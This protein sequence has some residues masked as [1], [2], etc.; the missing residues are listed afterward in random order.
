LILDKGTEYWGT[1]PFKARGGGTPLELLKQYVVATGRKPRYLLVDNA[2]E[3]ISQ[4]IVDYCRDNNTILQQ[5]VAYNHTMQA[6]VEGAIVCFKQHSRVAL[7]CAN[8]S[9][10]FWPDATLDFKCKRN[11]IWAKRDEHGQLFTANDRLQPAFEGSYKTVA[12]LFGSR[13]TGYLPGEHLL[14]KNGSFGDRFVEGTYLRTDNETP[15]IRMY[16]IAL[17]PSFLS[18]TSCLTRRNF[19]SVVPLVMHSSHYDRFDTHA[20]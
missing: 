11:T 4:D 16:C 2:K 18:K 17:N 5:V 7:V 15:R 9:T 10:R 8:K 3:F 12:I 14:V 6:R 13:V 20:C 19:H 1:Y